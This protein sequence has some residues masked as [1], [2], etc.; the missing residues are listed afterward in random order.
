MADPCVDRRGVV[1]TVLHTS[2]ATL[3][4]NLVTRPTGEAVRVAIE[5]QLQ[6]MRG[7]T[8]SILDFSRI[9]VI[10]F[11]CADEVI[12]KLLKKYS[13]ADRPADAFFVAHGVC[14]HHREPIESVLDHH[15][16]LL[17]VIEDG[18]PELWGRAPARLREAWHLL[19][20][21]G[22]AGSGDFASAQGVE[23]AT[24]AAWLRR[25]ATERVVV[26]DDGKRFASLPLFVEGVSAEPERRAVRAM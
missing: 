15:R 6:E 13:R 9:G 26:S 25:L 14:E 1:G 11:S 20:R 19:H 3:Y 7:T 10:D 24:A 21:M 17:V 23:P 16:L 5:H 4:S 12:A 18:Q 22:Q 8:L 2:V